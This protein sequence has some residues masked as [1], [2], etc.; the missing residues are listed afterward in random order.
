VQ[1]AISQ[2][3]SGFQQ[4]CVVGGIAGLSSQQESLATFINYLSLAIAPHEPDAY[5]D[6]AQLHENIQYQ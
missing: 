6:Y 2:G 5:W 1:K 4:L 3:F